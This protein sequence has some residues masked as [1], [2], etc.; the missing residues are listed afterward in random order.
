MGV[1]SRSVY[2]EDVRQFVSLSFASEKVLPYGGLAGVI[3]SSAACFLISV[4]LLYCK[5]VGKSR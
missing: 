3:G 4:I 5:Q 2:A 1:V